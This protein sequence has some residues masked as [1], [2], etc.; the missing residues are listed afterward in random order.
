VKGRPIIIESVI[1]VP[2]ETIEQERALL[3]LLAKAH[4]ASRRKRERQAVCE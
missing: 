2:C 3:D 4:D 1:D